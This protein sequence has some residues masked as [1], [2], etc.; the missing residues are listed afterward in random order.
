MRQLIIAITIALLAVLFA[1]QNADPVTVRLFFWDLNNT[2]LALILLITLIIGLI[3]G[4]L[5]LAPGIYR[6]NQVISTQKRKLA[7]FESA[8]TRK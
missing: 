8:A 5:F 6:R 7:E 3:A 1:L 4:M 2:S